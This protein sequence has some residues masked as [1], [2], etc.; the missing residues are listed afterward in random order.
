MM[1]MDKVDSGS[2]IL[3]A[4]EL[5]DRG[6]RWKIKGKII[7]SD[8]RKKQIGAWAGSGMHCTYCGGRFHCGI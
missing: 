5:G 3:F 4:W 1:G 8:T 6:H 2:F 7:K